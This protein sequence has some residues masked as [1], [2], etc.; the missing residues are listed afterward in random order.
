MSGARLFYMDNFYINFSQTKE[1]PR[2][3]VQCTAKVKIQGNPKTEN[4][5]ILPK[6]DNSPAQGH[7]G[8]Q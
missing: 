8:Q 7:P 3:K 6:V 4:E 2:N 1:G 5:V